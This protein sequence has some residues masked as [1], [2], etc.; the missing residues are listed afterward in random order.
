MCF[1]R[2]SL[3]ELFYSILERQVDSLQ[4]TFTRLS[5]ISDRFTAS[6]AFQYYQLLPSLGNVTAY[7]QNKI[8]PALG[9]ECLAFAS[10]LPSAEYIDIDFDTI[11]QALVLNIFRQK[12]ANPGGWT[13]QIT[14]VGTTG[15][16]EVGVLANEPPTEPEELKL[17]GFLT[18]LGEDDKPSMCHIYEFLSML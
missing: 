16:V 1:S 12:P 17:G 8:C 2:G 9:D 11:S 10:R 3:N 6:S 7:I 14:S 18:V 4:T 13:E 5:G 15:K